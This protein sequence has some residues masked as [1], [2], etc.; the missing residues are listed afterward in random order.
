MGAVRSHPV[1]AAIV[2]VGLA[3]ALRLGASPTRAAPEEGAGRYAR[4]TVR[5]AI[6]DVVLVNQ[7][8]APVA[9][10]A[11]LSGTAPVVV[12]FMFTTCATTCPVTMAAVRRLREDLGADAATLRV[13]AITLDPDHDR[14]AVLADY[15]RRHESV[16]GWEFLTGTPDAIA[17]VLQAFGASTG[18]RAD[19]R[20]LVLL[21]T[22]NRPDWVRIDGLTSAADLAREYRRLLG[23]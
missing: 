20:P 21:R 9:L 14:P 1:L 6:P 4:T 13:V 16:A 22:P 18:R 8:G 11:L 15:A 17:T 5:Y 23:G 2:A 3:V 12:S 19:H 7:D 10:P